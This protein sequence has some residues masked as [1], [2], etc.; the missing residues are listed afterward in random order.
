MVYNN[1][2]NDSFSIENV[3]LH[4]LVTIR[5]VIRK[6]I[7]NKNNI[8]LKLT[9]IIAFINILIAYCTIHVKKDLLSYHLINAILLFSSIGGFKPNRKCGGI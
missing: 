3:Y 7:H 4:T 5:N 1:I 2:P 8:R 9:L 6:S